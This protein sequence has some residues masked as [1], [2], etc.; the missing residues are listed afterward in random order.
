MVG[1][2]AHNGPFLASLSALALGNHVVVMTRF[3]AAEALR[4]IERH[5]VDWVYA[6]PTMMLRIWRLPEEERLGY[7][8]SSLPDPDAPGR[9]LPTLAQAGMD[10]VVGAGTEPKPSRRHLPRSGL[11]LAGRRN[12]RPPSRPPER[13]RPT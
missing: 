5:E 3:D 9:S 6:V 7:D 8:L 2:W 10:R 11:A 1:E 12:P 4:L 13:H